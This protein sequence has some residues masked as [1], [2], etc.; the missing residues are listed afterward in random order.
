[1][2]SSLNNQPNTPLPRKINRSLYMLRFR[3][4]NHILWE[5]L[6]ITPIRFIRQAC[7]VF[8]IGLHNADGVL[9]VEIGDAP[10]GCDIGTGGIIKDWE[11]RDA[12]GGWG[13]GG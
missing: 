8:P 4:I 5:L 1:M 2:P 11:G 9:G 7:I 6:Q 3:R 10:L 13:Q 12:D